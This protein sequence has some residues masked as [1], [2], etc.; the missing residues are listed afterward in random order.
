M[1]SQLSIALLVLNL[2]RMAQVVVQ[3]V[4]VQVSIWW[5]RRQAEQRLDSKQV[6]KLLFV[7]AQSKFAEYRHPEQIQNMLHLVLSLGFVLFFGSVAPIIVPFCLAVFMVQ[8]RASAHMLITFSKRSVPRLSAGIGIW[9]ELISW[10]NGFSVIFAGSLV[11]SYGDQYRS[12]PLL[13]RV[14]GVFIHALFIRF[15]WYFVDLACPGSCPE[16]K[17][18]QRR[19]KCVKEALMHRMEANSVE[20]EREHEGSVA[21]IS[22]AEVVCEGRWNEIPHLEDWERVQQQGESQSSREAARR[23]QD[24]VTSAGNSLPRS[25]LSD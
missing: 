18:L 11:A 10:M 24:A 16:A 4:L 2:S 9:S 13:T 6:P 5:E 12:T 22:L 19:R 17:L 21:E 25:P 14:A 8:L 20:R 7:E 1:R 23:G 15:C 3:S